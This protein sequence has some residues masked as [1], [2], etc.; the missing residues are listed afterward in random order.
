MDR[1]TSNLTLFDWPQDK[2]SDIWQQ[3]KTVKKWAEDCTLKE[4]FPREDYRELIELTL[5]Y[6]GGSLPARNFHLRKPG[7]VHHARFMSKAIYLLKME[8]MSERFDFTVEE[9]RQV[10]QMA[11]F[12]SLFYARLFLRS[13]IAVFAPIDDLQFIGNM[14]WFREE[15]ETIANAVLLSVSRHCWYLTEEL[16]VLALFNEKLGSF[17]R[18]LIARKLFAT[19]RPTNFEIGK[20]KFPKFEKNNPP[21]LLDLIGPRSW[22]IF[23]LIGLKQSQDWM[24]LPSEYWN[25]MTDYRTMRDFCFNLEVVNDCAE[26]GIKIIEDFAAITKNEAQF[27]FLLQCVEEHRRIIPSFEQSVLNGG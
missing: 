9:R 14:M 17:T 25:K 22:L 5:I 18:Y 8:L 26:R 6:L 2:N 27:Q 20:P 1:D 23:S 10:N 3:A 13:R 4:T 15:N 24:Q 12:I 21:K 16:V 19:P 11:V 7:A